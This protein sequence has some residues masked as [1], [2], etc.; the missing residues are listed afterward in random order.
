MIVVLALREPALSHKSCREVNSA[1]PE[2]RKPLDVI[3]VIIALFRPEALD[4]SNGFRRFAKVQA[5]D[6]SFSQATNTLA[7]L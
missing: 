7:Y 6:K 2:A 1:E 3:A 5:L 4:L